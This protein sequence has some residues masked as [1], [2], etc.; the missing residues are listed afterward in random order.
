MAKSQ[1]VAVAEPKSANIALTGMP[2]IDLEEFA[3]EG[4]ENI[5]SQDVAIPFLRIL[6]QLS[7]QVN[8]RDGA[9]IQ[10]AEAGMIYNTVD[11]EVYDGE[12]GV[13]VIPVLFRRSFIEWKPR[14]KGGGYVATYGVDDPIVRKTY[15][16]DRGNY[17][18]DNGNYLSDTAEFYVLLKDEVSGMTKR[19]LITM[20]SSQLKKARMWN[21]IMKSQMGIGK[22]GRPY[23][24]AAYAFEYTLGT[25][26]ERNDKGSWFG[27]SVSLKRELKLSGDDADPRDVH[28]F[29]EARNF[30]QGIQEGTVKVKQEEAVESSSAPII[31]NDDSVPF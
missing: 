17:V 4:L 18:L 15:R 1:S 7:P 8:K 21:S 6:A 5:T 12:K 2:V 27:W 13:T 25:A 11:N 31:D 23:V 14:E 26:E 22:T 29:I 28:L 3:N 20:T 10:G 9:Y 30:S 24:K 16:D 19:C